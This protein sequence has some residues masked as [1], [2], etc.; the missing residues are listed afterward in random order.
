M[1]CRDRPDVTQFP[2]M[3]DELVSRFGAA[4]AYAESSPWS[5]TGQDS[6]KNQT[7]MAEARCTSSAHFHRLITSS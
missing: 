6:K 5:M 4:R 3:V 1:L 7:K 2:L